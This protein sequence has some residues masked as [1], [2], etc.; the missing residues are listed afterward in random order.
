MSFYLYDEAIVS[1]LRE[2]T[3]D[4]RIHIIPPSQV[5]TYY[6]QFQK[7]ADKV[8]LP[9]VII[10]RLSPIT[11]SE[12]RNQP[13][14]LDGQLAR[15]SPETNLITKA[16]FV[17]LKISWQIDVMTVDRAS[18]DEIIRELI[19]FFLTHPRFYVKVPYGLDIEQNFDILLSPDVQDNSDL[20]E[21]LSRGEY[22]RE[23]ITI[24]TENAHLFSSNKRY[25][26][27]IT[28][29]AVNVYGQP[30]EKP[31]PPKEDSG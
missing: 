13:A 11:V 24:S 7:G 30:A 16:Q 19:F 20:Q 14:L 26:T 9:A 6:A 3:K 17:N 4:S 25:P 21:F 10:S 28:V 23:T 29:E 15:I 5:F 18:C 1:C 2:L 8:D 22:F 27:Y 12:E 31:E